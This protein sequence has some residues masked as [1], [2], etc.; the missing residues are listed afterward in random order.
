MKKCKFCSEEI[1]DSAIKCRY[2]GEFLKKQESVQES[3]TSAKAIAHGIKK[4]EVDDMASG[5][6]GLLLFIFS[7]FVGYFTHWIVGTIIFIVGI[8]KISNIWYK[9]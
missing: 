9:E 5:I 2:C 1:Q 3:S 6:L 7:I 8:V 4:K